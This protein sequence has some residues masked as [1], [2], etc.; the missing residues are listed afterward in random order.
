MECVDELKPMFVAVKL[1]VIIHHNMVKTN[2][3]YY[4]VYEEVGQ[5]YLEM[6]LNF[7]KYKNIEE[8]IDALVLLGEKT[9]E[10]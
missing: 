6:L 7:Y 10:L 4:K 5:N 1:H 2:T 8:A 9:D 3:I